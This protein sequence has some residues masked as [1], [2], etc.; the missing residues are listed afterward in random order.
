MLWT[1]GYK[2][3]RFNKIISPYNEFCEDFVNKEKEKYFCKDCEF[4]KV[5]FGS[6]YEC[7]KHTDLTNF[8]NPCDE[9]CQ[10]FVKKEKEE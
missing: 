1:R 5:S 9:P 3:F 6:C 4:F 8:I 2:C 10:D 7:L